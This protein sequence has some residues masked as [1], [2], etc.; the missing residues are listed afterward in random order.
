MRLQMKGLCDVWLRYRVNSWVMAV[1]GAA[2]RIALTV[3]KLSLGCRPIVPARRASFSS[4]PNP[5]QPTS[6]ADSFRI[7]AN[8]GWIACECRRCVRI[9]QRNLQRLF[10]FQPLTG[11]PTFA[12]HSDRRS[13][14]C[15]M[16]Y[17]LWRILELRLMLQSFLLVE[18]ALWIVMLLGLG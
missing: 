18:V 4:S 12:C 6:D 9:V 13:A 1:R 15:S 10:A 2:I 5:R 8:L 7:E 17:A 11:F 14:V 16:E 3:Q